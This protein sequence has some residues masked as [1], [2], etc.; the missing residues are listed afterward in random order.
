MTSSYRV[1]SAARLGR[2]DPGIKRGGEGDHHPEASDYRPCAARDEQ[3]EEEAT[4]GQ[5]RH[6]GDDR[7]GT[8][9]PISGLPANHIGDDVGAAK[10][11]GEFADIEQEQQRLAEHY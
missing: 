9:K 10:A 3:G 5:H 2:N 6:H 1:R 11:A 7:Y 4:R 8:T